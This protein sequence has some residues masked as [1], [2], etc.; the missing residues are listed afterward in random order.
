MA[1]TV[2][3]KTE[4]QE[5]LRNLDTGG[6]FV[7]VTFASGRQYTIGIAAAE[8]LSE[9]NYLEE[10]TSDDSALSLEDVQGA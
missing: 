3:T 10:V 4:E 5:L 2:L 7:Q 6:T 1:Q 8:W 9:N